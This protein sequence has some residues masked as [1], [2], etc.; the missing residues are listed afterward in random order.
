M[1]TKFIHLSGVL[2]LPLNFGV[3]ENRINWKLKAPDTS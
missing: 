2:E 1:Q 3:S